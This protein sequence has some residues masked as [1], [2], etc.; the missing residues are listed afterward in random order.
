MNIF[1][2]L[3]CFATLTYMHVAFVKSPI[4]CLDHISHQ[5][6]HDGIL[7]VE[8]LQGPGRESHSLEKSYLKELAVQHNLGLSHF[9]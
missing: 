7:R 1:Q 5:W 6:P 9:K 4:V 2:A 3:L 8:V